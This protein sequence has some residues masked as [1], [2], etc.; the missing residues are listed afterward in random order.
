MSHAI[1]PP[2]RWR[3][4]GA[5]TRVVDGNLEVSRRACARRGCTCEGRGGGSIW[6]H[7][8][9]RGWA[10]GAR[11]RACAWWA[12]HDL[13]VGEVPAWGRAHPERWRR[14]SPSWWA[15]RSTTAPSTPVRGRCSPPPGVGTRR[16]RTRRAAASTGVPAWGASTKRSFCGGAQQLSH[17]PH[18][19]QQSAC[20]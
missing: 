14:A 17:F 13:S 18:I 10:V 6:L 1:P 11:W 8:T 5:R 9:H 7:A 15:G 20:P 4:A 2:R 19:F 16:S 12:A 3:A